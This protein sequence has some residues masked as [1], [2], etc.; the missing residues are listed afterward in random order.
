[1]KFM[2]YTFSRAFD[3]NI[4]FDP[5]L[6]PEKLGVRSGDCFEVRIRDNQVILEKKKYN[7]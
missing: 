6:T 5:D 7:E 4:I 3:G 1:M 2:D